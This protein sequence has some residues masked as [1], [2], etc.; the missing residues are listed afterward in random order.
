[1]TSRFA[2]FLSDRFS[3]ESVTARDRDGALGEFS[4]FLVAG[5]HL[6]KKDRQP[7]LD[8]L[9]RREEKGSTGIGGGM[10]LPHAR[11]EG[12]RRLL[13]VVGRSEAGVDFRAIDGAPV[14]VLFLL[15][16]PPDLQ[17]D[18]LF[19]LSTLSRVLNNREYRRFIAGARTVQGIYDTVLEAAQALRA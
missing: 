18:Y 6:R 5:G 8:E 7:L 2:G 14:R 1:M 9:V 3:V 13:F 19:A 15:V 10:A 16:A 12:V 11:T 17:E 4:D